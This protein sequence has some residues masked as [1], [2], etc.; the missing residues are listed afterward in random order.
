MRSYKLKKKI[1]IFQDLSIENSRIEINFNF[2]IYPIIV[3]ILYEYLYD[4]MLVDYTN[5]I[6]SV[7]L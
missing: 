2:S 5:K 7:M 6:K 3:R 4:L 1:S